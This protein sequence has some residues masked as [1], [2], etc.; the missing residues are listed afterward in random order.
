MAATVTNDDDEKGEI[1]DGGGDDD[2]VKQDK[3]DGTVKDGYISYPS[4]D[5]GTR[6]EARFGGRNEYRLGRITAAFFNSVLSSSSLM[7]GVEYE[8]GG[9]ETNV[10]RSF[11]RKLDNEGEGVARRKHFGRVSKRK[12]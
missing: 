10:G 8:H 9:T 1:N 6:M 7:F 5:L 2:D 4:L 3:G 12:E 11:I